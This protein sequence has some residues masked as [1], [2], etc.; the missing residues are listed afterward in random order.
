MRARWIFSAIALA[1]LGAAPVFGSWLDMTP[2]PRM[3]MFVGVDVSGSFLKEPNFMHSIGFL[4]RYL[5]AH[6][7]GLAGLDKPAALF[8]GSIGGDHKGE[9]KVFYPIET[10]Q[11]KSPEEIEAELKKIFPQ[12]PRGPLHRL[13]RLFRQG[14]PDGAGP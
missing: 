10:F 11:N 1:W 8:V 5:Y 9:P 14:R 3:V 12:T 4:A 7:N 6:L 13:Q 2:Q